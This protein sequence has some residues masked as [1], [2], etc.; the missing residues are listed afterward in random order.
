MF[1][2]QVAP[3]DSPVWCA[4][5]VGQS[6]TFLPKGRI[7][8]IGGE[9]EDHYDPDFCIY[10]DV[11]VHEPDGAIR[12]FCYPEAV[13]PPTDFHTAT[14]LGRYIYIIGSL[15]YSGTRGQSRTPM[16]RL[17]TNSFQIEEIRAD[18]TDP[19]W[20]YGHA[21]IALSA[22][23]IRVTGGTILT[24]TGGKEVHVEKDRSFI[25]DTRQKVWAMSN[26]R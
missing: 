20:I 18:G 11:F 2:G 9:H 4:Q 7:I 24:C 12:I 3:T 5:R 17:D 14:L 16:Y 15:G 1:K 13:F 25:F 10:N 21:A 19:G 6:I 8:Q 26:D 22:H 23:Q